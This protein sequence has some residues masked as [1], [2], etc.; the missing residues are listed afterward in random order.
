MLTIQDI[1]DAIAAA[2][3]RAKRDENVADLSEMQQLAGYLMRPA[4]AKDDKDTE[5][6]FR[7]LAANAA[8][9]REAIL[10]RGDDE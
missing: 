5:Y 9:I 3:E 2:I 4:H 6:R 8:N 10:K 1:H 7:V